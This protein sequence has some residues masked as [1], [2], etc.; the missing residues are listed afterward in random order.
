MATKDNIT[1]QRGM[2]K[3]IQ[4]RVTTLA[5]ILFLFILL[6]PPA[7]RRWV[8]TDSCADLTTVSAE[9]HRLTYPGADSYAI[10]IHLPC[11]SAVAALLMHFPCCYVSY[12]LQAKEN[13]FLI[14]FLHHTS[15]PL[16]SFPRHQQPH[17]ENQ[18][19]QE[20]GLFNSGWGDRRLRDSPP[21][22][23]VPLMPCSVWM[24]L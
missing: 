2:L 7:F 22:L 11:F 4:T 12:S 21:A 24:L 23:H 16:R 19:A 20:A 1:F 9:S 14:I 10:T 6:C 8:V 17:P 13:P 5:S 3:S 15:P 18:F